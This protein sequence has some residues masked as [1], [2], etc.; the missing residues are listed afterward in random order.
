MLDFLR[1]IHARDVDLG[2][3]ASLGSFAGADAVI[4]P[5]GTPLV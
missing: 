4:S 3:D 1:L 5:D 2:S